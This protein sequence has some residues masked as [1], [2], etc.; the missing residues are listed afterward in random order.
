[1]AAGR[2]DPLGVV[3]VAPSREIAE[4]PTG[5]H[6]HYRNAWELVDTDGGAF[7]HPPGRSYFERAS[8]PHRK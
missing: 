7:P 4:V 2:S 8:L 1:M 5:V 3:P 6:L